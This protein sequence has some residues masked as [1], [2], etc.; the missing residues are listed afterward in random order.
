MTNSF[1][2]SPAMSGVEDLVKCLV[3]SSHRSYSQGFYSWPLGSSLETTKCPLNSPTVW[4]IFQL[5]LLFLNICW[6]FSSIWKHNGSSR[7]Q[8][9]ANSSIF[10]SIHLCI[11]SPMTGLFLNTFPLHYDPV[12]AFLHFTHYCPP[13]A[14]RSFSS[15]L[16]PNSPVTCLPVTLSPLR[17]DRSSL[18]DHPFPFPIGSIFYFYKNRTWKNTIIMIT[19]DITLPF[20]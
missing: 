2:P 9:G 17:T 3:K 20:T 19:R 4:P 13:Q 12:P 18:S 1:R 7:H 11:I 5:L 8:T 14:S 6:I 10:C 16:I 15:S